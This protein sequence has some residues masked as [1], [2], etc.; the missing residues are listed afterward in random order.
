MTSHAFS[1]SSEPTL[2]S[3]LALLINSTPGVIPED[4]YRDSSKPSSTISGFNTLPID[5]LVKVCSHMDVGSLLNLREVSK[6]VAD[7]F[8]FIREHAEIK[9]C[10]VELNI[11]KVKHPKE[12]FIKRLFDY[13][14][15]MTAWMTEMYGDELIHYSA[16][17]ER[18]T[19]IR[20]EDVV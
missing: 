12:K 11:S 7:N 15:R 4:T 8:D 13:F 3:S 14:P 18:I 1:D 20:S 10:S 5:L 9:L 19:D 17:R 16:V 6:Y 2:W